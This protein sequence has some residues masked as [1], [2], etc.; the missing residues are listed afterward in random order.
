MRDQ[1]ELLTFT[2]ESIV[3]AFNGKLPFDLTSPDLMLYCM[4]KFGWVPQTVLANMYEIPRS[5]MGDRLRRLRSKMVELPEIEQQL[6]R[7][8]LPGSAGKVPP[9]LPDPAGKVGPFLPAL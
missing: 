2:A 4:D 3:R 7:A 9:L 6:S 5:T 1:I 8:L